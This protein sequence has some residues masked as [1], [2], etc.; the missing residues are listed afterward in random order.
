MYTIV[1]KKFTILQHSGNVG[2]GTATPTHLL[3]VVGT[4]NVPRG[5][6]AAGGI[7]VDSNGN[8][9]IRLG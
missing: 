5:D 4:M 1:Y 9:I 3:S 6:G 7:E 8:V 2:I